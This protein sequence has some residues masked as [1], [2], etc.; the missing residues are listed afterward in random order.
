MRLAHK[1]R[2]G[3]SANPSGETIEIDTESM[4]WNGKR[5]VPVMGE[6]HYSRVPAAEWRTELLKM[7]AGGINIIATTVA[8][9]VLEHD[10]RPSLL[11]K[12]GGT[13]IGIQIEN[14][15][16]GRG[17]LRLPRQPLTAKLFRFTAIMPMV[18]G[19]EV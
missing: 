7:K 16:R 4:L 8:A 6:I 3:A 1:F 11:W 5:V 18:F 15:Y 12:D 13:I 19:T 10:S 2:F 14:E 17:G 9:Q